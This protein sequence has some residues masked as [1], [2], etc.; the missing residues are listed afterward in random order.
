MISYQLGCLNPS[1]NVSHLFQMNPEIIPDTND[2]FDTNSQ[3]LLFFVVSSQNIA[4]MIISPPVI[5]AHYYGFADSFDLQL[6][7]GHCDNFSAPKIVLFVILIS[8]LLSV[9]PLLQ[10][11]Y[12]SIYSCSCFHQKDISEQYSSD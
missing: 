9:I 12:L 8:N 7:Y 10:K 11:E 2:S 1:S 6:N 5:S 4:S 3:F